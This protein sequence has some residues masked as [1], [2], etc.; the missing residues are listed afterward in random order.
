MAA[1][2]LPA[3]VAAHPL[4]N[5]T[6]NHY[7][8]IRVEPDRILLDVVIDQ[9]E[10][11]TFQARLDFDTDG[12]GEVSDAETDVGRAAACE[13]LRAGLSVTIDGTPRPLT[14]DEAGLT[15]P[16]GVGGLSTMR[17]VCG[18]S[19]TFD[20]ALRAGSRIAFADGSFADRLGWREIVAQGSGVT[21]EPGVG[22]LRTTSVSQRLTTY[23]TSL[24]TQALHDTRITV[25]ATPGGLT[26]AAFGIGDA[27]PLA[28]T[29]DVSGAAGGA[30]VNVSPTGA[31]TGAA[32]PGVN[33]PPAGAGASAA[34][35]SDVA[36]VNASP[37]GAAVP[38]G[39]TSGDLPS[40]FRSADLSPI[41]LLVSVLTAAALG[42]GHALTPGHGKTLMA[43]YLV[44]TRGTPLHAAGLG[45]SVTVS[46]TL[47]ILGLA[48]LVVGAQGFL[49]PDL[50]VKS[51]PLVAAVSI[52]LIGGWMLVGEARR[53]RRGPVAT[54]AHGQAPDH[55][56]AHGPADAHEHEPSREEHAHAEAH[57]HEPGREEHAHAETHGPVEAHEHAEAH[58]HSEAH[59]PGRAHAHAEE[60]AGLHSHGGVRHSHLP[61]TGT[62]ISWRSLFVL[63]LAGGLIPS[64]SAL[65]ILLG[66]I[67]AGRP[68]FGFVLVVAFGLGMAVVMGGIGLALVL[69]RSRLDHV[70][71]GSRLGRANGFV[72]LA[73]ASLVFVLGIY[74]TIQAVAGNATF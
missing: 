72:P 51:A 5:F 47:G 54:A 17:V 69:A 56:E 2:L 21:L 9:A 38:G 36:A 40:I 43:A 34:G 23:P 25:V 1:L 39:V 13:T 8:G 65:L 49:P 50:I 63:G 52:V 30:G 35:G 42:A 19:A 26:A 73:A 27:W 4:G 57:E 66:S 33:G 20:G 67:A 6:I 31:G 53:R 14:L 18:F 15:F 55:A 48:A 3:L 61:P 64:T 12:D 60:A 71:A 22:E 45:L 16:P 10:I 68:A 44:G 11:P 7:A 28:G 59:E 29:G 32:I 70:D 74:L 24:L 41:V 46:H 62:T 37:A 58:E